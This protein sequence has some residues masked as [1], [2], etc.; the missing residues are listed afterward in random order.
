[1]T[2]NTVLAA[3][4][5]WEVWEIFLCKWFWCGLGG[6]IVASFIKMAIAAWKTGTFDFV[7]LVSTGGMP[8][9]HSATVAG[10]AFGIGY[11]E[12][13][14]TPIAVLAT[15]FAFITMFDAATVR[16]AAG[17]H[18]K[19]LNAIVRDIKDL[20]FTPKKRFKELLGHTRKEV[21][22]GMVTG[23]VWATTL[24]LLWD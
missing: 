23:I 7:Y 10:L 6:W 2:E 18:A 8:S 4:T 20:R 13:F 14:D 1:M 16:R 22:W 9:S 12:G 19:V 15:A 11:T 21:I 17:E 3:I 24:C 5:H